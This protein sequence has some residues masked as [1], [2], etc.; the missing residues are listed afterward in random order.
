MKWNLIEPPENIRRNL[1][2]AT[3]RSTHKKFQTGCVI[4][5]RNGDIVSDGCS[6]ISAFRYNSMH[7]VHAEIHALARGR[8]IDLKDCVAFVQT[9]ARKSGNKT[10]GMPC[11]TC[12]IA[13]KSAGIEVA[14]YTVDNYRFAGLELEEDISH[15]KVYKRRK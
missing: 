14:I 13:L 6:H 11:L 8:Y 1:N 9:T 5:N 15:L 10:L 12:A 2:K 4:V 7:S 3:K